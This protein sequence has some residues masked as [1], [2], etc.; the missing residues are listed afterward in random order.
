MKKGVSLQQPFQVGAGSRCQSLTLSVSSRGLPRDAAQGRNA[1]RLG[2]P[3]RHPPVSQ[4][5]LPS[6]VPQWMIPG[7]DSCPDNRLALERHP[8]P[9]V[10]RD[11]FLIQSRTVHSVNKCSKLKTA[12]RQP[13]ILDPSDGTP[14]LSAHLR[15]FSV[16]HT[17][18]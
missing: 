17:S 4:G 5:S 11:M 15:I 12:L 9:R 2:V 8:W 18:K 3:Q 7:I 16:R 14:T 1:G 13:M 6:R 10:G